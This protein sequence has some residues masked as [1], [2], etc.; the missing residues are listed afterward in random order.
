M[1]K[2]LHS[3]FTLLI[4]GSLTG[5]FPFTNI[6]EPTPDEIF[7]I[8]DGLLPQF[9][10]APDDSRIV[11]AHNSKGTVSIHSSDLSG[12]DP[13][14]LTRPDK[15]WDHIHPVW[16][17]DGAHIVFTAINKGRDSGHLMIMNADG[18]GLRPL[19]KPGKNRIDISPVFSPDGKHILYLS[20]TSDLSRSTLF[21]ISTDG[22]RA[23]RLHTGDHAVQEAA[24]SPDGKKVYF[25]RGR[26][27]ALNPK[28]FTMEF[29]EDKE[30]DIYVL[31]LATRK[32]E[33]LTSF[34]SIFGL[35]NLTFGNRPDTLLFINGDESTKI[36]SVSTNPPYETNGIDKKFLL[37]PLYELAVSRRSPDLV[38][39]SAEQSLPSCMA[40]EIGILNLRTGQYLAVTDLQS[41]VS[42]LRF[43]NKSD[44]IIFAEDQSVAG[45][46]S[47]ED[48]FM[49]PSYRFWIMNADGT[50]LR[51]IPVR[52]KQN[53]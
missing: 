43:L 36:M 9:D 17:P 28:L 25:I 7:G 34:T 19:T 32:T 39:V 18:T 16:S 49:K 50:D 13:K 37:P 24:F 27:F 4:C 52:V 30:Q 5:C 44:R 14:R 15:R 1:K 29:F 12:N 22:T 33:P 26:Q 51:E 11:F 31:D 10:V 38:A 3:V 2:F 20:V 8:H 40:Y 48:E 21:M 42:N 23:E 53:Q 46:C 6:F 45:M 47:A 41:D 35:F